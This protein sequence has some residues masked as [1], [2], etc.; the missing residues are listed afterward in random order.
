MFVLRFVNVLLCCAVPVLTQ[1]ETALQQDDDV[2][3][4]IAVVQEALEKNPNDY[5]SFIYLSAAYAALGQYEKSAQAAGRAF[6]IARNRAQKLQAARMASKARF[7]ARQFLQA[8]WWLRRAANHTETADAART[9]HSEFQA[10]RQVD[11]SQISLG[12]SVAPSENIN[13]GASDAILR[14]GEFE[15]VLPRSALAISGIEYSTDLKYSYRLSSNERQTTNAGFY[16]YG[17]TYSLSPSEKPEL[18]GISGADYALVLAEVF[19]S[20]R[21]LVFPDVGAT[22]VSLHHGQT[23]YSG[24]PL[25]RY[26][27]LSFSQ[28]FTWR[29]NSSAL[30]RASVEKQTA[31]NEVQPDTTIYDVLGSYKA[32]LPN[33]D[34]LKLS[35]QTRLNDANIET[36]KHTDHRISMDYSLAKPVLGSQLSFLL[37]AG[38]KEYDTFSLSLNGRRDR[39]VSTG[40]SAAIQ[41]VSYFGFSPTLSVYAT[42]TM[43]NVDRFTTSDIQAK[44]GFR[45]NF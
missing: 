24:D 43:S 36:Y 45:S 8:R 34:I 13:G 33:N 38:Y 15:F 35:F 16:V 26:S 29:Q 31:L 37:M 42:R 18:P 7:E 27:K 1:A 28:E 44:V 6:S 19:L 41:N 11:P 3:A 9:V 25:W 4:G 39:Y 5:Q 30:V 2:R 17:R 21:R 22:T 40:V 23:W 12:F 10:I 14:L 32:R 20:H